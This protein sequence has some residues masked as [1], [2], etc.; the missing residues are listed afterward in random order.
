M[1]AMEATTNQKEMG[2]ELPLG[3]AEVTNKVMELHTKLE[4]DKDVFS[5][6]SQGFVHDM[7]VLFAGERLPTIYQLERIE[8]LWATYVQFA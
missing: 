8:N 4:E 6:E 1:Y 5:E 2:C 7:V 3:Y